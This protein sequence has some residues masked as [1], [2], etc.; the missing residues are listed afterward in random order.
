MATRS[1]FVTCSIFETTWVHLGRR[2]QCVDGVPTLNRAGLAHSFA[3]ML[4]SFKMSFRLCPLTAPFPGR[5]T[6]GRPGPHTASGTV[7]NFRC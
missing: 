7:P 6:Q 5:E 2:E 3:P 4:E 1:G